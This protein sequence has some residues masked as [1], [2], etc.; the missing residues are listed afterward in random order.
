MSAYI[1]DQYSRGLPCLANVV[2]VF[3]Y[4]EWSGMIA[5]HGLVNLLI[6]RMVLCIKLLKEMEELIT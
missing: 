1:L 4:D 3:A 2:F 5:V 6:T